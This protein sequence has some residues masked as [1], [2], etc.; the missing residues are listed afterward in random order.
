MGKVTL[1]DIAKEVGVSPATV[2]YVL[3]ND[4]SQKISEDVRKKIVQVSHLLGYTKNVHANALVTGRSNHIGIYIRQTNFALMGMDLFNYLFALVE[5]LK[6]QGYDTIVLPQEYSKT[7][8]YVDAILCIGLSNDDF[9]AICSNNYI[10]TIAIDTHAKDPWNFEVS[11]L[12][13]EV[14]NNVSIDDYYFVCYEPA[15]L[16][17]KEAIKKGNENTIFISNFDDLKQIETLPQETTFVTP[18]DEI[19]KWI[20]LSFKNLIKYR[21]DA[22]KKFNQ[23]I[24]CLELAITHQEVKEHVF[25][26]E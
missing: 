18:S 19:F 10:P 24:K 4:Q 17:I 3:N 25:F 12:F 14:K 21:I 13:S 16:E 11:T 7:V 8:D 6:D 20:K 9:K 2:S 22:T 26:V 23:I 5:A 1:K 15:S